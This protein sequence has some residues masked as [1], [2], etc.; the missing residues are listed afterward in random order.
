MSLVPA[1]P[2]PFKVELIYQVVTAFDDMDVGDILYIIQAFIPLESSKYMIVKYKSFKDFEND[3]MD[4]EI[5][6]GIKVDTINQN[7]LADIRYHCQH[8]DLA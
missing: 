5:T 8:M 1:T 7:L 3:M 6:K 4:D 2:S